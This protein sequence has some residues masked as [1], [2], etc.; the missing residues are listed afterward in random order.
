MS[1]GKCFLKIMV[2]VNTS[3]LL[4]LSNN[5]K[6]NVETRAKGTIVSLL[7]C[8]RSF[9][10]KF[11]M[12]SVSIE[13]PIE[14]LMVS[15][16]ILPHQLVECRIDLTK[17]AFTILKPN[18]YLDPHDLVSH[19]LSRLELEHLTCEGSR[20]LPSLDLLPKILKRLHV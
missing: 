4:A 13:S 14:S 6:R 19:S 18:I 20:E 10:D 9:P 1:L 16:T 7:H 3:P 8:V 17:G 2:K 11:V 15:S 5:K 12:Y